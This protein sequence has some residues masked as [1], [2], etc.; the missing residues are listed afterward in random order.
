MKLIFNPYYDQSVYTGK[1]EGC[2]LGCKYV[3]PLGLLD[4]LE[5]RAGLSRS[6]PGQ[7]SRIFD[8]CAALSQCGKDSS[9]PEALFYWKSFCVDMLSVSRRLLEWR[10][11]LVY[12]GVKDL[13]S[14]PEGMSDGARS[15]LSDLLEVEAYFEDDCSVGDRWAR[16]AM[17]SDYLSPDWTIE[18][19]MKEELVDQVILSCLKT[20]GATCTFITELPEI[21]HTVTVNRFSN[22]VDGYQWAM[23]RE[24]PYEPVYVNKDNVS[25]NGVLASLGMP[26]VTAESSEAYTQISQLFSSGMMLFTSPVDYN[27]LIPYLSV[28]V[29]PL[30]DYMVSD[31]ETLRSALLLHLRSV[32]GFGLNDRNGKQWSDYIAEATVKE[33]CRKTAVPLELCIGQW[34]KK[35]SLSAIEECCAKWAQWC[36]MKAAATP[37]KA[38]E[39]QLLTVKES[40]ELLP[41][42]LGLAGKDRFDAKELMI[43]VAAASSLCK[44]PTDEAVVGS[45]D[46]VDDIKAIA[47]ECDKVVWLDC[48]DSGISD[49]QYSFLNESDIKLMNAAGMKIPLYDV[50]LMAEAVAM[51]LGWSYVKGELVVLTPEKVECRKCYPQQIPHWE[52]VEVDR[53]TWIP[54]GRSVASVEATS[55]KMIH[56]VTSSIFE[57]LKET[58]D[59]GGLGRNHESYTSLDLLIQNPFD[60]VLQEVFKCKSAGKSNLSTVKGNVVHKMIYNA[61]TESDY[62]W[63]KIKTALVTDF[64]KSFDRAV[65][66]VGLELLA[67]S[68]RLVYN[69]FRNIVETDSLPA[70]I[71]IVEENRLTVVGSE[72]DINVEFP[73]IG[74]FNAKIDMLLKNPDGRY[75]IMDF[76][77][78]DSSDKKREDEIRDNTEM[79]LALYAQVV[80]QHYGEGDDSCVEAIGYFML[81]Q[82][83]FITEYMGLR[84]SDHVRVVEKESTVSVFEMVKNS[85]EFRM[86]QLIPQESEVSVIEEG[87]KMKVDDSGIEGY[88]DEENRFPLKGIEVK[89]RGGYKGEKVTTC[90]KNV[91]LKGMLK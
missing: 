31:D 21:K 88:H 47:A 84:K 91:V 13:E 62:D 37:D 83:V 41:R 56:R 72:V 75:V 16:L 76:K 60:Y 55:Q 19:R 74:K 28:P 82:G 52:G 63:N 81:R 70:F 32:G 34:E 29:H 24:N 69:G 43:N 2:F 8:Y 15:I 30:N 7:N 35:A 50:Q 61:V 20:C 54:E 53:T 1:D 51:H 4:E 79:Q 59:N 22:L 14:I 49:Y 6:Y 44:Y 23:T 12:A 86:N 45:M 33:E 26:R 40:F 48:Y 38:M 5:M 78:T 18:V 58:R 42:F 71:N 3:G 9:D 25:L 36:V 80:R 68:N 67:P 73:K 17:E 46:V 66:E 10:D 65:A 27:A 89:S 57:G 90:G 87:E 11:A 64:D 39:Q 85:Y 77:W